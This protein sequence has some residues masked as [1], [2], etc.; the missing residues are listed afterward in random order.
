MAALRAGGAVA[1]PGRCLSPLDQ[2]ARRDHI[3]PPQKTAMDCCQ[4]QHLLENMRLMAP[5]PVGRVETI[6]SQFFQRDN[7]AFTIWEF[8]CR[9]VFC[10]PRSM[11]PLWLTILS[12]TRRGVR[13]ELGYPIGRPPLPA[14]PSSGISVQPAV[15]VVGPNRRGSASNGGM[16]AQESP[17]VFDHDTFGRGKVE[18][19]I[20]SRPV[21]DEER[22]TSLTGALLPGIA[23]CMGAMAS[24]SGRYLELS[25]LFP[26]APRNGRRIR[27]RTHQ[28]ADADTCDR[29]WGHYARRYGATPRVSY[30]CHPLCAMSSYQ[31]P[32]TAR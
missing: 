27:I 4:T 24:C 22:E 14:G 11:P 31:S 28:N 10:R 16:K 8:H 20:G 18:G 12:C 32:S 17:A 25:A 5:N 2:A 9:F 1:L 3:R 6:I 21:A 15:G 23:R 29:H 13:D 19:L 26:Q 7:R 30:S